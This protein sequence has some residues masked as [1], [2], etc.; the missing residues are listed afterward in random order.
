MM[1]FNN[2][3]PQHDHNNLPPTI[4]DLTTLPVSIFV[5]G[6]LAFNFKAMI[7]GERGDVR[8]ALFAVSVELKKV[9]QIQKQRQ[10]WIT[11]NPSQTCANRDPG[12]H[13]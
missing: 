9:I 12:L 8:T 13:S 6:D 4:K 11:M 3:T 7:F 1:R 5:S 10:G 2:S